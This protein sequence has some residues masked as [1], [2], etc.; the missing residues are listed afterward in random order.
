MKKIIITLSIIV[1][2]F[3]TGTVYANYGLDKTADVSGLKG[4]VSGSS[5]VD[6][7]GSVV[8]AALTMVGVLFLLLMIYGGVIWMIARGNEQQTD[9]ALGTIKAAVIGLIIVVAS[10][11]ITTFVFRAISGEPT[12]EPTPQN[13]SCV[14][15]EPCTTVSASS[16]ECGGRA[17][18]DNNSGGLFCACP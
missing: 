12:T 4:A 18:V 16:A 15:T 6:I 5:P 3:G 8:G 9:K 13:S 2:L 14:T 7:I 17:C 1:S 10:F 11:A